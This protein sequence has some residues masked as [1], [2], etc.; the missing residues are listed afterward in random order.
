MQVD[1]DFYKRAAGE[2]IWSCY[3][4]PENN[5]N[6]L[7]SGSKQKIAFFAAKGSLRTNPEIILYLIVGDGSGKPMFRPSHRMGTEMINNWIRFVGFLLGS[8]MMPE[9]EAGLLLDMLYLELGAR[10][11]RRDAHGS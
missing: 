5:P 11:E 3:Q 2:S 7:I 8:D 9:D 1:P 6:G 10:A 4:M